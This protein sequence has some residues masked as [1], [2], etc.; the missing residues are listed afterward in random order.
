MARRRRK[1][2]LSPIER[3][4]LVSLVGCVLAIAGPTFFRHLRT[5]K[6]AEAQE[7]LQR[8]FDQTATYYQAQRP[9]THC[10][11]AAAG[12]APAEASTD[13]VEVDFADPTID[14]HATWAAIGFQP[15]LKTRFRY[16]LRPI[17]S[18]CDISVLDA[19][20]VTFVAEGD[21]DGDGRLSRYERRARLDSAGTW[22]A[23]GALLIHDGLE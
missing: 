8:M 22:H 12:P 17:R 9:Q 16:S 6:T 5:D 18:G 7:Q 2:T 13:P 3:V 4:A 15:P 21:L 20:L 11:P 19:D 23:Y 10:L 1:L 14:G